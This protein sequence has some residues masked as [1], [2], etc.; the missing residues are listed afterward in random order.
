[1]EQIV[2]LSTWVRATFVLILLFYCIAVDVAILAIQFLQPGQSLQEVVVVACL[3]GHPLS[4]ADGGQTGQEH[5]FC[6]LGIRNVLCPEVDLTSQ[7]VF[8]FFGGQLLGHHWYGIDHA[9]RAVAIETEWLGIA[10]L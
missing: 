3:G 6:L 8:R 2:R 5:P 1:M 10:V 4:F 7:D 9:Q